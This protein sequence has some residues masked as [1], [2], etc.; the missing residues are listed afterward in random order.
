MSYKNGENR[1]QIMFTSL[2]M[3]VDEKSPARVVDA[4][5]DRMASM[6]LRLSRAGGKVLG[7]PAY[8]AE[9]LLK[10]YIYGYMNRTRS[11]RQLEMA[12]LVNVEVMWLMDGLRPD[13]RTIANFRKENTAQLARIIYV[14]ND[15]ARSLTLPGRE[16][17]VLGGG[18]FSVDGTRI[19]A[20]QSKDGCFTASKIDDRIANDE[21]RMAQI[22]S[23]L[24]DM[25]EADGDDER[26]DADKGRA[27]SRQ[28]LERRLRQYEERKAG[29]ESIRDR[30][31]ET[32]EQVALN[33]PDSR[34]MRNHYGGYNPSYNIQ[35]VVDSESHMIAAFVAT[36]RCT[37][38]GLLESTM[39][40]AMRYSDGKA[41][42]VADNGYQNAED[43][44]R[45]LE[46]GIVP[47]V[48]LDTGVDDNGVKVTKREITLSFPYE[49]HEPTRE[50]LDS[51]RPEDLTRCLRSGHVPGMYA[52]CLCAVGEDGKAVVEECATYDRIP[53]EDHF[54][55]HLT[56][57]GMK[58]YAAE[59]GVFV[60]D[61]GT[62]RV[63]CPMGCMLRRKS[64]RRNSTVRYCN[65]LACRRCT[66]R[67]FKESRTMKWKEVSFSC[68]KR[69]AGGDRSV[70]DG[71]S[72]RRRSPTGRRTV[73]FIF[74]PD[75]EKTS[76]RKCLSEH[77]F[78]TIKRTRSGDHFLLRSLASVAA[79]A[80][81]LF[82]GYNITRLV[83]LF[84]VPQ[85]LGAMEGR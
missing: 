16:E 69:I 59:H 84:S 10:L 28:E 39:Q 80:S 63:Y 46:A 53:L 73:K 76:M 60:R 25:D 43:M 18:F 3:M 13:F 41:E 5:V 82:L 71:A 48:I 7:R 2:E 31:E 58:R 37:D 29:H 1:N 33:D 38:H 54:I 34:L 19:R 32:G 23:Y 36:N 24:E 72:R 78:G 11:S 56:E 50:E 20:N 42:V 51:C 61:I 68:G 22:R 67:C 44:A 74:R 40:E 35:S 4:F 66:C 65:K 12:C 45:C 6:E 70:D 17:K 81:L 47:N 14:F 30:I 55:D 9:A 85:I 21:S 15:F 77:P 8:P 27:F 49:E 75:P 79:E 52:H 26:A 57:D 62:D 83:S 64:T